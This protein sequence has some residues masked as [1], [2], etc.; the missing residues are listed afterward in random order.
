MKKMLYAWIGVIVLGLLTPSL[1]IGMTIYAPD[2]TTAEV[3]DAEAEAYLASGWYASSAD[4]RETLYAL[5]GRQIQVYKAE[6]PSYLAVGWY[7]TYEETVSTMYAPDGCQI[8]VYKAE[9][10]SYIAVGWYETF[11]ETVST[12]YAPDGRQIQVY[13]AEV[14]AYVAVGWYETQ[15][16]ITETLYA[17]GNR[18]IVVYKAEVPSYL[19]LGWKRT[20][21]DGPMIA[22]TFDDGPHGVYTDMILDTLEAYDAKA[23]F[24]VLGMQA[25]VYPSQIKRAKSLGCDIGSHT[26][27]HLDLTTCASAKVISE[28]SKTNGAVRRS[29]G[30]NTSLFRPPY[31]NHNAFIR[32]TA[33][34]P[35][36]LWNVDPA[37]WKS[38]N[39]REI[40]QHVISYAGDGDIVLMHDIYAST[41]EAVRIIVPQLIRRGYKLVTVRELAKAKGIN[42][43]TGTAYYGF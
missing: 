24:F 6:V 23:T 27:G 5:D 13:K 34:V 1:G 26:Y 41:A 40:A 9:V 22:L 29:I 43:S 14:P 32:S 3:A 10:P 21:D 25:D 16:E 31:G 11:E 30:E 42:L 4:V 2:G 18:S 19:A 37:D 7:K 39:A 38:K 8:Q 17:P 35:T 15:E 12:L 20:R 36:I 33:G 28:I